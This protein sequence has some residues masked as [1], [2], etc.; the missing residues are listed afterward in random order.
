MK[1]TKTADILKLDGD[2]SRVPMNA[3]V[4]VLV[5]AY[6]YCWHSLW[7]AHTRDGGLDLPVGTPLLEITTSSSESDTCSEYCEYLTKLMAKNTD[8]PAS[9]AEYKKVI[10]CALSNSGYQAS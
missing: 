1:V 2:H 3:G 10:R 9:K 4:R 5:I 7:H 6:C 8:D